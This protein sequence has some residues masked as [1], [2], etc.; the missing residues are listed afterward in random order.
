DGDLLVEAVVK[1]LRKGFGLTVDDTDEYQEDIKIL[2]NERNP[3]IF[4]EIKG[5]NRGVKREHIN[6]A[7]IHRERSGLSPEF[8]SLLV[9]N[10]HIKNSR[11]IEEKDKEVPIEQVQH[12]SKNHILVLRTLDL[13]RLLRI[14]LDGKINSD[15]VS[16][17]FRNNSGWLKVSEESWEI[18][19][20]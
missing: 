14:H 15:D 16:R 2:D 13:L 9:I 10:T 8:P 1:L 17:L 18:V 12:A 4:G 5:T 7:D 6:Q 11:T 3:I 20:G 19:V